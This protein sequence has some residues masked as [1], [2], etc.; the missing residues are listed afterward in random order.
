MSTH[1]TKKFSS[2]PVEAKHRPYSVM[3]SANVQMLSDDESEFID[4]PK[5]RSSHEMQTWHICTCD[6]HG[7]HSNHHMV[8]HLKKSVDPDSSQEFVQLDEPSKK[9]RK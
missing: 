1:V 9:R 8:S 3:P 2:K 6:I 5:V 7:Y 4:K